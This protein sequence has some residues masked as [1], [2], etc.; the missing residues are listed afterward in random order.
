MGPEG[1]CGNVSGGKTEDMIVLW[2]GKFSK[3]EVQLAPLLA[4]FS[5]LLCG[6]LSQRKQYCPFSIAVRLNRGPIVQIGSPS[7]VLPGSKGTL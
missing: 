2:G 6:G 5:D 4:L 1:R 7:E 3:I